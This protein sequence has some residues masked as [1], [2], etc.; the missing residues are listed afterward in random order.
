MSQI[1][2]C[3]TMVTNT[4]YSMVVIVKHDF[5]VTQSE[6]YQEQEEIRRCRL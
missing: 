4:W 3:Q 6:S 5:L 1:A 2:E